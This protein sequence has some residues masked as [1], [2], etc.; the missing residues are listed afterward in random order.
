[1]NAAALKARIK[2]IAIDKGVDPQTL[3]QVYFM[4]QFLLRLSHYKEKDHIIVK[5]GMLIV[6]LLGI[7]TRSTMDIDTAVKDYTLNEESAKK[8]FTDISKISYDDGCTFELKKIKQIMDENEYQGFRVFFFGKKEKIVQSLHLDFSTGDKITPKEVDLTYKTFLLGEEVNIKSYNIET[9]VAE[10][11]E[12]TFS[13]GT[14]NTRMKDFYDL[15]IINKMLFSDINQS[16]LKDAFGTTLKRRDTEYI[17]EL[18]KDILE[19]VESDKNMLNRWTHYS[20]S[21]SYAQNI[22]YNECIDAIKEFIQISL[23]S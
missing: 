8:L 22:T 2:N 17:I 10:K 4:D 13:R 7:T 11:L 9:F 5:G 12:T 16:I 15:Y 14:A 20:K 21:Y 3:M 6:A 23:E 18:K 19:S 1:M